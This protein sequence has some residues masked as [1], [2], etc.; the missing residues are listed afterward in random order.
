MH[1][2]AWA[3]GLNG[4]TIAPRRIGGAFALPWRGLATSECLNLEIQRPGEVQFWYVTPH[5]MVKKE[6]KH[7]FQTV[8]DY[9]LAFLHSDVLLLNDHN[10]MHRNDHIKMHNDIIIIC[11]I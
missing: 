7:Y 2:C 1:R 4:A 3:M 5:R 6:R 11:I 10:N 8:N 9:H